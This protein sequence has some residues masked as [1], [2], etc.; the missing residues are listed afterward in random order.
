MKTRQ[1]QQKISVSAR[2]AKACIAAC[3]GV[4]TKQIE[5]AVRDSKCP[6]ADALAHSQRVTTQRNA[7]LTVCT[8]L[9]EM[10]RKRMSH[11]EALI[12]SIE[13]GRAPNNGRG[14]K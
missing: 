6:Y 7:L 8:E 12:A 9:L 11:Y 4:P 1:N 13:A 2:R 14:P 3:T 5:A 10:V